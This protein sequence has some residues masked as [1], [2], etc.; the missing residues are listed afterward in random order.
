MRLVTDG[1]HKIFATEAAP[2][3]WL[4]NMGMNLVEK[5][6]FLKRQLIQGASR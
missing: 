5:L 4:R 2:V 3:A 6:P 1:L